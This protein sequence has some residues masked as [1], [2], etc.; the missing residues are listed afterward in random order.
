M[1]QAKNIAIIFDSPCLI[2]SALPST[3]PANVTLKKHKNV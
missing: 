2:L 3:N 1:T